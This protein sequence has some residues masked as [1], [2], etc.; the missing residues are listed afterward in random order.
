MDY[1]R[2]SRRANRGNYSA[3]QPRGQQGPAQPRGNR[4]AGRRKLPVLALVIIDLAGAAALFGAMYLSYTI[5]RAID[6]TPRPL[7]V[8]TASA[9]VSPSPSADAL[10]SAMQIESAQAGEASAE[11]TVEP[12]PTPDQGQFGAQFAD[13]FSD[14]EGE[15]T[16]NGYRSRDISV[17]MEKKQENGVTW[18]VADIYVR[19]L[20]NF[21]TALAKDTFGSGY[22]DTTLNMAEQNKAIVAISGDYY[23]NHRT[24]PVIR[25]GTLYRNDKLDDVCV[26]YNDGQMKTF[27]AD[28]YDANDIE[29]NGAWQVWSFGPKLL[30]DGQP[31][32]KFNST[33]NPKNPRAAIGYYEPG[34]YCF[35]LV[36]GRQEGYSAGF[37]LKEMSQLF[38]DM[39]CKAAYNLDGGQSA[40]MVFNGKWANQPYRNG[41]NTSD[42]LYIA[43]KQ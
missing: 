38:Y 22:S 23:S 37:T 11:P 24:G 34:H 26:L 30:K 36:D 19:N 33:L 40:I 16:E 27:E 7:P 10:Q 3:P 31:M 21:R 2:R 25:N 35:V 17:T 42:I 32:E 28:E 6:V 20:D 13:K 9:P 43:E 12:T 14:G 18:Y 41:R 15:Y 8:R 5:P 29:T 39:G 4:P 1:T